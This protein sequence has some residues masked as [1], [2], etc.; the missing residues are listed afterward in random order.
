M[1]HVAIDARLPDVGQGGVLSVVKAMVDTFK[2]HESHIRRTWVVARQATW[3]RG[4]LP[5]GDSILEVSVPAGSVAARIPT[6][7]SRL[8]PAV[9]RVI[10]DRTYLDAALQEAQVDVVHLPY[11][12]GVRTELPFVYFPH[13]LQH[14]HLPKNFTAAQVQHRETRWRRRAHEASHIVTAGPHVMRD[15]VEYWNIDPHKISVFPFP[16]ARKLVISETSPYSFAE[17]FIIYPAVFWPHKNHRNLIEAFS[18]VRRRGHQIRL[19]LTGA[20]N[21]TFASTMS[22]AAELHID[23]YVHYF[24]HVSEPELWRLIHDS[25]AV[26]IP[27][28]FEAVSITAFDA[29]QLSRP[30]VCSDR[31]FFHYQCGDDATYFDPLIPESISEAIISRLSQPESNLGHTGSRHTHHGLSL[32]AFAKNLSAVYE[33]CAR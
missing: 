15:L 28:L 2:Q 16:P 4:S 27:S 23:E 7:A 22:R 31:E 14:I 26:V 1:L 9:L 6:L 11:Q 19:V 32:E 3:W 29:M 17:P 25:R 21:A 18:M 20:R 8:A 12:D 33:S 24:G 10:G 30:I 13:D 5:S